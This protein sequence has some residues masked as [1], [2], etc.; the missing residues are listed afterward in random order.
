MSAFTKTK[1]QHRRHKNWFKNVAFRFNFYYL[2]S[3]KLSVRFL[4]WERELL[5]FPQY[6][7]KNYGDDDKLYRFS[8]NLV[9][10]CICALTG[11]TQ[12][13]LR[14]DFSK[15]CVSA[16]TTNTHQTHNLLW[17]LSYIQPSGQQKAKFSYDNLNEVKGVCCV[18]RTPQSASVSISRTE[19]TFH[20]SEDLPEV[21]SGRLKSHFPNYSVC[22]TFP[23]S[24]P[25]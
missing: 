10:L 2:D 12:P 3:S 8:R 19:V 20:L 15:L 25:Y 14:H 23:P 7:K 18:G 11:T 21:D 24:K 22:L 1:L 4:V 6:F 5:I 13:H 9:L 17:G 16:R